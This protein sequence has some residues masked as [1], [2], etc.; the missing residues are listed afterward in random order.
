MS[1]LVPV[2]HFARGVVIEGAG[3]EYRS[4]DL[5]TGFSTPELDLTALVWPRS[6]I[7]PAAELPYEEIFGFLVETARRLDYDA[8]PHLQEAC[9]HACL[10]NP[11]GHAAI[12]QGYRSL[13]S[14][15]DRRFM[16]AEVDAAL[17]GRYDGWKEVVRPGGVHMRIRPYAGR[18]VHVIAGN[19]PGVGPITIVRACLSRGVH[20]IK[21][22]SNELFSTVAVLATMA[23]IDP[24]H[25]LV[26]SFSAAYWRGGDA[27]VESVLYRPQFF[28]KIVAWGGTAGM[29]HLQQYLGPGLELVSFDP[30]T[31]ISVLGHEVFDSPETVLAA[32]TAAAQDVGDQEGCSCSRIQFI[33]GSVEELDRYC[34]E[35]LTQINVRAA[36]SEGGRVTP[37]EIRDEVEVLRHMTPDF[38]VWGAIDGTGLVIRSD[39]PVDFDLI[40]RTVN[41]VPVENI[42]DA[43]RFVNVATQTIGV[44]PEHRKVEVRN[45]FAAAGGQRIVT[46]GSS[47][48]LPSLGR[49][50]DGFYPLHRMVR[51]VTDED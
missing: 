8:N 48:G 4:R 13:N 9:H 26:Q 49:P 28:D 14:F 20:L 35:L 18:M 47:G 32:A 1:A 6:E 7:P 22:P 11:L 39:E 3:R 31:S 23:E 12:E 16:E 34:E 46:L 24:S 19:N 41:V 40:S 50:H 30:K 42:A 17:G 33:E 21:L 38:R 27:A 45:A 43:A 25:P 51:W 10:V 15:F 5:E 36:K 29:Q 2:R 44:Y 37:S